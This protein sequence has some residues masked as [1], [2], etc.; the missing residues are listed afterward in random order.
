[1]VE[2]N[3][4]K[5]Y[6]AVAVEKRETGFAILLDGKPLRTPARTEAILPNERLAKAIAKEW[7]AQENKVRPDTMPLTRLAN[8]AADRVSTARAEMIERIMAFGRSDLVCYRAETP[9]E[10][11]ERQSR[12]WDPL[13]EW[14]RERHGAE[15]R[16]ETGLTFIEQPENALRALARAIEAHDD[17]T[18]A[19]LYAAASLSS[20]LVIALALIDGRLDAEAA[21]A[22]CHLD[23]A[24]Q[25]DKWGADP[26]AQA[27]AHRIAAELKAAW[28]FLDLLQES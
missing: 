8:T 16:V 12:I 18:L 2:R 3:P 27:R 25:Q 21:F 19:A 20:S 6:A 4:R 17:F 9:R 10:L 5:F 11:A 14:L 7:R 23:E 15:L 28:R 1:V 24:Y 26:E 22:A 13:L